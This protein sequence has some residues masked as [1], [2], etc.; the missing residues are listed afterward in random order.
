MEFVGYAARASAH[1]KTDRLMP[2]VIQSSWILIAPTLFA[3]SVY[4]AFGRLIHKLGAEEYSVIPAKWLTKAFV[5]GDV[6]SFLIQGGSAGLMIVQSMATAGKAMVIVGL[7]IQI[8]S[9]GLFIITAVIFHSRIGVVAH[10]VTNEVDW[11]GIMRMLYAI[12]VLIMIRSIFRLVEYCQG[13]DGYLISHEWPAYVF[14]AIPMFAVTVI[15]YI[16]FPSQLQAGV[17]RCRGD[18]EILTRI[19]VPT[20]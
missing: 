5:L 7:I 4:M 9:F 2:Y 15:Y 18:D 6:L 10:R 3:A 16:K 20:K 14:D 12:S 11:V 8:L 17:R 19:A 13:M 1:N